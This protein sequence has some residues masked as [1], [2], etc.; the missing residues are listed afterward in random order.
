LIVFIDLFV[1]PIWSSAGAQLTG[2][3]IASEALLRF[4][5]T[6]AFNFVQKGSADE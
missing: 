5:T 3:S 6:D 2:A 1:C 4:L